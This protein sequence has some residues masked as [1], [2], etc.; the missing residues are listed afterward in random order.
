MV[1]AF[2]EKELLG[3]VMKQADK[4]TH[5]GS[6]RSSNIF[7][8][9]QTRNQRL[10]V[11]KSHPSSNAQVDTLDWYKELMLFVVEMFSS[12][13]KYLVVQALNMDVIT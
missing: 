7:K 1:L 11:K 6:V 2:F 9:K 13:Q 3:N 8:K 12:M 5:S 10:I 4:K